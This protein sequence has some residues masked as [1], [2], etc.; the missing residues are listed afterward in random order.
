[1]R[2]V[3][4]PGLFVHERKKQQNMS[5]PGD[6]PN[7]R[8]FLINYTIFTISL[9]G[10]HF[11]LLYFRYRFPLVQSLADAVVSVFL[12]AAMLFSLSFVVRFARHRKVDSVFSI[13]NSVMAGLLIVVAW[14]FI[15]DFLLH[16]LFYN[17]PEY[18]DFLTQSREL[19]FA[20]GLFVAGLVYLSFFLNVYQQSVKEAA[21]RESELKALVEKTELQALRNQ[22]NPHFIYNSLNSV[23]SLTVFSPD[24][25]RDMLG[26][27]S[28]FLRIALRKDVLQII[29]L[30]EELQNIELYLKIEKVRFEDKLQWEFLNCSAFH[31]W[32]IPALILQPLFENAVKHGVQQSTREGAIRLT[33]EKAEESLLLTLSNNYDELFQRYKGEGVGIENVRNRMRL[34]YKKTGLLKVEAKNG[35]FNCYLTLPQ[36]LP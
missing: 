36:S 14:M 25:A 13:R 30:K 34:I 6:L 11:S 22:L 17:Q 26:N 20:L 21:K 10:L 16:L 23:S 27:L 24:K 1:M 4:L 18:L 9:A 8:S 7:N 5:F 3:L 35:I 15:M 33:C 31:T 2:R 19:R 29:S 12:L 32:Q 28:D